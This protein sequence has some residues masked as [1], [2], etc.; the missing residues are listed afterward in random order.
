MEFQDSLIITYPYGTLIKE[1]LKKIIVKSINIK[2]IT[3]HKLLLIEN[4]LGLGII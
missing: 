4:K 2:S 1:S 3:N